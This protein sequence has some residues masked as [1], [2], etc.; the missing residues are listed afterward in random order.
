MELRS[1]LVA[2]DGV[3]QS[4]IAE[5]LRGGR[6]FVEDVPR[7]S[8]DAGEQIR[9]V[10]ARPIDDGSPAVRA[11]LLR[12]T[13]GAARL[14][15][16]AA[17]TGP[18]LRA[19]ASWLVGAGEEPI[20]LPPATGEFTGPLDW[21]RV[22]DPAGATEPGVEFRTQDRTVPAGSA[23]RLVAATAVVLNRYTGAE[24]PQVGSVLV[25]VDDEST[26]DELMAGETV[27][28]VPAIA[29][30]P[31][32]DV[33]VLAEHVHAQVAPVVLR[34][35]A[36]HLT[37]SFRT[38]LVDP[39]AVDWLLCSVRNVL[40][41]H[42]VKVGEIDLLAGRDLA[43]VG[44]PE[45][46][47][48]AD[49][50]I[51]GMIAERAA[52]RPDA[53]AVSCGGERLTYRQLDDAA[54]R[55]A[56]GLARRGVVVGSRVGVSQPR[57][58]W[59]I[60]AL[61]GVLKAGAAYVPL[62]PNYPAKRLDFMAA[63][64]GLV[65]VVRDEDFDEAPGQ[66]PETSPDDAA[67]VIYTSGSTGKPK[68]VV[69]DHR[70]VAALLAS[71]RDF[72]FG[73]DDVW[74][75]FHS[76]A[77]DFSV[78][79]IWGCLATGG[80]LVVVTAEQTRDPR[81]FHDLLVDEGVTVLNQ[82]PSAFAQLLSADQ[83]SDRRLSVRLL[84]F[85]GEQLDSRMLLRWL[86]RNPESRCR[87]VNMYGITETTV[88]CT[89]FTVTREAALAGSKSVGVAIPGWTLRVLDLKGR[90]VP[91]GVA[92]EIVVGGAG[93]TR[94]YLGRPELTDQR[95]PLQDNGSR[96]YR[97][98]DRGRL[99]VTGELEH[100]GRLDSQVKVRGH[101][102]ELGEIKA[103][104]LSDPTVLAAAVVINKRGAAGD[105]HLDAY[106]VGPDADPAAVR[107][108][109]S[110][111]LPAYMVPSTFTKVEELPLTSNG[112][113]DVD[114]LPEPGSAVTPAAVAK[115]AADTRD[116]GRIWEQLLGVRVGLD[117]NLFMVGG[118]SLVA[119]RIAAEIRRRRLGEVSVAQI[120][121][122]PTI[123]QLAGVLA[124]RK[125][126]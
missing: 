20:L 57:G 25:P 75:F 41:A 61:L 113:L 100:H 117:D 93:V 17:T 98:G 119:A 101:R 80:R 60:A 92:G 122:N 43:S 112:K 58:V 27:D 56:A 70:N 84:V 88:H 125:T 118:N 2:A 4:S 71:T 95:F 5:R 40:T 52:E 55:V 26:V 48:G 31:A 124:E 76:Y 83:E 53:I 106:L 121:H 62:D 107:E 87:A 81:R 22:G 89:W 120:Y 1:V 36:D 68:G 64:A 12:F 28:A 16:T 30:E 29:V 15:V 116:V 108:R 104:L 123:R 82:T 72:A 73:G 47:A 23:A 91:P 18:S 102:I 94:G 8:T 85:G 13:D 6:L 77:F 111:L 38:D 78:W 63:D 44:E 49:R 7:A 32:D 86:D 74:T 110:G 69:V 115:D 37:A 103:E 79:E 126:A 99:L 109:L 90:R 3:D 51:H 19:L 35:A 34:V 59:L 96:R 97:S 42:N 33:A 46:L 105:M 67:Y 11:V 10:L 114:R 50:T 14:A 66:L 24:A 9:R 39:A 54:N 45:E 65:T 21:A